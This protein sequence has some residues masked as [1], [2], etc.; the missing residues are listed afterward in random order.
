MIPGA[1]FDCSGG[2]STN[3]CFRVRSKA[4]SKE[5]GR[6]LVRQ[7]DDTQAAEDLQSLEKLALNDADGL[8]HFALQP[9]DYPTAAAVMT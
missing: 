2:W 4:P 5:H 7:R 1:C 3:K 6:K 8:G 9:S